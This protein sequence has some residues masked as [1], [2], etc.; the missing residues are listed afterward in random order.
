MTPDFGLAKS[1]TS[2]AKLARRLI[3]P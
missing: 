1:S 2:L 3:G